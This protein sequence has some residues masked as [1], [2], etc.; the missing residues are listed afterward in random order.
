MEI[1]YNSRGV[2]NYLDV[3]I[4]RISEGDSLG[5]EFKTKMIQE[6]EIPYLIKPISLEL[7]GQMW[8]KYNTNS[9]YVL[10]RLFSYVRPDGSLLK[11]ILGQICGLIRE[12]ENFFLIPDELVID[13][14]Y[15][16][17]D[18]EKRELRLLYIPGYNRNICEQLKMFLEFV[19]RIFDHRDREGMTYMYQVYDMLVTQNINLKDIENSCMPNYAIE[20]K[21]KETPSFEPNIS[22][23]MKEQKEIP[24]EKEWR[25]F[26]WHTPVFAINI[27]FTFIF[28]AK[29]FAFGKHQADIIIGI[30]LLVA[31]II[32]GLFYVG[33]EEEYDIDEDMKVQLS[34]NSNEVGKL[35]PLTN[36]ALELIHIDDKASSIVVGRGKKESD[37]RLPTTQISRV[38]ACI[39]KNS[40]GVFVE[41]RASTNGTYVNS[42][43]II[44]Y[45]KVKINRGDII[46]FANEEFFAS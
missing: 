18:G 22:T 36:G 27:I 30:L 40:D 28:V 32:H 12:L 16:F 41:D 38:H 2:E 42:N 8:L 23:D 25:D 21:Y 3:N 31:M 5:V 19:M 26:S 11:I 6:N 14:A 46:S 4:G 10:E 17:Y 34:N 15:M 1:L 29:Y 13:P 20:K 9:I 7:D 44:A 33:D 45:E 24:D 37:Y 43:R 39:Y 35:V